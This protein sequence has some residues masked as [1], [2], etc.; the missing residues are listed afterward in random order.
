MI[1]LTWNKRVVIVIICIAVGYGVWFD[2][3]DSVPGVGALAGGDKSY[4][5][6]NIIGHFIP[7]LFM[8]ALDPRKI[9]YFL[10]GFLISTAVMDLPVWG[11]ERLDAH[12]GT[13]W[14]QTGNTYSLTKWMAFYYNPIGT[15]GVWS[16]P[17][18]T[19]SMMFVS[20]SLRLLAAGILIWL[21]NHLEKH[22]YHRKIGL[23]TLISQSYQG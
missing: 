22:H 17:F 19:A 13:L 7:G 14:T 6:W 20:V 10:A 11:I 4:Q 18:P 15:Y 5:T 9:E 8:L 1:G 16:G 2:W 21:Q 12:H 3:L 23:K